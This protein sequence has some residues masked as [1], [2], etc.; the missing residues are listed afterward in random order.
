V[1]AIKTTIICTLV[2]GLLAGSTI[3][4][5]AQAEAPDPIAPASFTYEYIAPVGDV[6]RDEQTGADISSVLIEATDRR[7]SG[8]LTV[9]AVKGGVADEDR[10]REVATHSMRLVNDAGTWT[11]TGVGLQALEPDER[12]RKQRKK[13]RGRPPLNAVTSVTQLT[14]DG[15]Y[16]GLVL[17]LS[18]GIVEGYE[19]SWGIIVP[20]DTVPAAPE[21]PADQS[22]TPPPLLA[23]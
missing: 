9:A 1:R 21:L 18:Y 7:A 13:G 4:V 8:V 17:F 16:A 3:G 15:A 19:Q 14:G 2:L 20:V 22:M 5:H 11:G 10:T 6:V 12:T 23:P